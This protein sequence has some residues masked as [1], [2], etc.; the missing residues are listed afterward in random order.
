VRKRSHATLQGELYQANLID[1][2]HRFSRAQLQLDSGSSSDSDVSPDALP[3]FPSM[4]SICSSAVATFYAPVIS[5]ALAVCDASGFGLSR[6][7][8]EVPVGTAFSSIRIQLPKAY[9]DLT[10]SA[11]FIR[12][13][14]PTYKTYIGGTCLQAYIDLHRIHRMFQLTYSAY[15]LY[16]GLCKAVGK[17]FLCTFC[18]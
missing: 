6:H 8:E 18:R 13:W 11:H 7:G 14:H 16:I 4:I 15:I 10:A 2:I 1:L 3:D 9:L 12:K 5:P 17:S